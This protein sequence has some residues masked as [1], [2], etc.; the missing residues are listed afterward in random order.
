MS[1]TLCCLAAV[2][3]HK[4]LKRTVWEPLELSSLASGIPVRGP[5]LLYQP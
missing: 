5:W 1:T 4:V 3:T 2:Q